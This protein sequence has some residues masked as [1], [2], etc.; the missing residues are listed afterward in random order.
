MA[1]SLTGLRRSRWPVFL[2]D[3]LLGPTGLRRSDGELPP[4]P[5]GPSSVEVWVCGCVG[6][7]VCGYV[8]VWVCGC[9][10]VKFS[11]F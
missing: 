4:R 3:S 10:T 8:G 1:D 11:V 9:E 5:Y 6:V 2:A 7:W